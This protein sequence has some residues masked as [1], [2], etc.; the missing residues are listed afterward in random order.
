MRRNL[1]FR[2]WF[3]FRQGW[4][5]YFAFIMAAVNVLV[6]T[7]YLAIKDIPALKIIFPSFTYYVVILSVIGIP[8]LVLAGYIHYK[9]IHAFSSEADIVAESNPYYYKIPPGFSREAVFP[10]Y[11]VMINVLVKLSK[12]EKLTDKDLEEIKKLQEKLETLIKGG[13]VG[14]PPKNLKFSDSKED[15]N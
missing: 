3:Y 5:T 7:Y 2:A 8:L 1:G 15:T 9:R 6:T 14:S 11:L 4:A 10:L 12:N 13:I